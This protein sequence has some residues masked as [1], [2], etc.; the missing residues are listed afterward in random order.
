MTMRDKII[1]GVLFQLVWIGCV[2][3]GS[4]GRWWLGPA[5]VL[6]FGLWQVPRSSMPSSELKLV[7]AAVVFGLTVDTAYVALGLI[8]YPAPGPW[9]TVAPIWILALWVGFA[10]TL[11]HSLAWLKG[12]PILATVMGAT[13]G[14]FSFWI[15]ATGWGAASFAAP[16]PVVLAVQGSVW[17]V[18]IPGLVTFADRTFRERNQVENDTRAVRRP[19][20]QPGQMMAASAPVSEPVTRSTQ[21]DLG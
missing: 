14:P 2:W 20:P 11:N 17:A 13:A 10:L 12:R 16:M 6:L 1:N 9:Q 4:S 3:G 15:G 5:C 8:S 21:L 19:R 18:I 7:A